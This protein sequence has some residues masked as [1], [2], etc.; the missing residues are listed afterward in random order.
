MNKLRAILIDDEKNNLD[1]LAQLLRT[2]CP[3]V[4]VVAVAM[5]ADDGKTSIEQQHPD[6]VFLD[7]QMPGKNGF[8][9]LKELKEYDFEL[10]FVTA[11]DQYAIQAIK[12]SAADYLLKPINPQELQQAVE[13][14]SAKNNQHAQNA[15]L[16]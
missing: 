13:R 12:F 11:F 8:E 5:N 7:I 9:L 16:Q 3:A 1:N 2:Y 6:L 10:V 4:E 14:I 15:Q